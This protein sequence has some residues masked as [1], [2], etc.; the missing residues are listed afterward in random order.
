MSLVGM[1]TSVGG[2]DVGHYRVLEL[3]GHGGMG[4]VYKAVDTILG[5]T[6]AL[7]FLPAWK[8]GSASAREGL[9]Q[10]ARYASALNHPNIVTVHEIAEVDG[11][12]FIVME[13]LNGDTLDRLIPAEG[14]P[15]Q[16]YDYGLQIADALAAAHDAGILHGDLKPRNI[17]ITHEGRLKILDFGLAGALAARPLTS[18]AVGAMDRFGTTIYMAPEQLGDSRADPNP[19]SE[20]FTFGLILDEMLCGAHPFGPGQRDAVVNAILNEGPKPLPSDIAAPLVEIVQ[21]CLEKNVERRFQSMRDVLGALKVCSP[22]EY[23][24][25]RPPFTRSP[26][27]P[28]AA[29]EIERVRSIAE[30]I[31]YKSVAKSRQALAELESL[32]E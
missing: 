30:R 2:R 9:I 15:E 7:K 20:I 32:I 1:Y 18:E 24:D 31:T 25:N 13:Y 21:R 4:E 27:L 26:H 19:R 6:V 3:I 14:L 17:M 23:R 28:T 12:N 8:R 16:A 22:P 29:A 10:E 11:V 5:R